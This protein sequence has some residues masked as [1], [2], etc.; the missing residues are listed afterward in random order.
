MTVNE[1]KKLVKE[2]KQV[3]KV[4]EDGGD[5][6]EI[7]SNL[8]YVEAIKGFNSIYPNQ[9]FKHTFSKKSKARICGLPDGSLLIKA[10]NGTKL[11]KNIPQ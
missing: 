1:K 3:V 6:T 5:L 4:L 8:L 11:W 10:K 7:Y 2:L 9:G